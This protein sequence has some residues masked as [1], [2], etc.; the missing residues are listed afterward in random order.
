MP[1]PLSL[2]KEKLSSVLETAPNCWKL[3]A[4]LFSGIWCKFQ[5]TR[6]A[7]PLPEFPLY[8]SLRS[9]PSS[10]LAQTHQHASRTHRLSLQRSPQRNTIQ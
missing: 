7:L 5:Q 1:Q 10:R 3:F 8:R 9:I 4:F 2:K 6:G